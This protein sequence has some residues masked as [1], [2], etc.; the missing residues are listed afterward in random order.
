MIDI[1]GLC[2]ILGISKA[3]ALNWVRLG[4]ISTVSTEPLLFDENGVKSEVESGGLLRRRRNKSRVSG[5]AL[6]GDYIE[7]EKNVKTVQKMLSVYNGEHIGNVVANVALRFLTKKT[8]N[9]ITDFINKKLSVGEADGLIEKLIDTTK[10]SDG[11]IFNFALDFVPYEDT[12]GLL[13]ISLKNLGARKRGGIYYT[14]CAVSDALCAAVLQKTDFKGKKILDPCCGTGNF[15]LTALK[16]GAQQENIYG[17]DIDETAVVILK[18]S[19][20]LNGVKGAHISVCDTLKTEVTEKYDIVIGNPPWGVKYSTAENER[21][22]MSFLSAKKR[23]TESADVFTEKALSLLNDNGF[24]CFVVP[25][26]V[27]NVSGHEKIRKILAQ[28][29]FSF[30]SYSGV[31]NGVFCPCVSFVTKKDSRGDCASCRVVN[32]GREHILIKNRHF[33]NRFDF[34]VTDAER[35]ILHIMESPN[36]AYL[37]DNAVF[38]LGIVTGNNGGHIKSEQDGLEPVYRGS[39]VMKYRLKEPSAFLDFCPEEFQQ[40]AKE[41][42]YRAPQKLFYRFIADE[43]VTAFDESGSLSLNSCNILIPQIDGLSVKY[44]M[45]VLNSR[46]AGFYF[47]KKFASVKVLKNQLEKLPI[48]VADKKTQQ[49]IQKKTDLLSQ[50]YDEGLKCEIDE[51]IDRLYGIG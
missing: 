24:L 39:D 13:Y 48:P 40:T 47:K 29:S 44:V 42:I 46:A 20:F 36:R 37:K 27:F 6:Y 8:G 38:A 4:K 21:L 23:G 12:L 2:E 10:A 50:K 25:Q 35:K 14:P 26:A 17:C 34:D 15:L 41:E 49:L 5:N 30:V 45:A 11:E 32:G 9:L 43:P 33:E 31:F 22:L 28:T 19:L 51:I 7:N 18:I 1:N 16:N 3:T